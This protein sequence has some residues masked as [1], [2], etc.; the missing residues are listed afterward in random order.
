MKKLLYAGLIGS[1]LVLGAV[2]LIPAL[3]AVPSRGDFPGIYNSS[4]L[5]LRD[6]Y[7]SALATD[8]NGRVLLSP[9]SSFT[10]LTSTNF[11]ATNITSTNL[12]V[13]GA[14]S[15]TNLSLTGI[16]STN[17]YFTNLALANASLTS[18]TSTNAYFTNL[19]LSNASLTSLTSTNIYSLG[20]TGKA[21]FTSA[22]TTNFS[23]SGFSIDANGTMIP[24]SAS[25][26]VTRAGEIGIDT[27]S[28]QLRYFGTATSTLVPFQAMT[29][30]IA[31]TSWTTGVT[32]TIPLGAATAAETWTSYICYTDTATATVEFGDGTNNTVPYVATTTPV[33]KTMSVNNTWTAQ[34]KRYIN[35]GNFTGTPNYLSC[36]IKKAYDAD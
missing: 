4:T 28:N 33:V 35:I 24:S 29:V 16:T 8:A 26:S 32:T 15:F 25:L 23:A 3:G 34:E 1:F 31:S 5:T 10:Q 2:I 27:T 30:T 17:A 36:S 13:S 14:L 22:T 19:A 6:G 18:I 7:G 12:Y 20:Y 9:I 11:T 21:N